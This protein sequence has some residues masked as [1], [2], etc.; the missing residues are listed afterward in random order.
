MWLDYGS[1]SPPA[2]NKITSDQSQG[3][4]EPTSILKLIRI[5]KTSAKL[6][7][8][9]KQVLLLK[10][11]VQYCGLYFMKQATLPVALPAPTED[12]LHFNWLLNQIL[13]L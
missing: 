8:I 2:G 11:S 9:I 10:L 6:I 4:L 3:N 1:C 13:I 12:L 7:S 5:I